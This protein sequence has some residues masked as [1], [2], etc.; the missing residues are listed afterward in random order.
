MFKLTLL[1][2]G[3]LWGAISMQGPSLHRAAITDGSF[4]KGVTF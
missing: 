2:T 1:Y 4:V 3:P